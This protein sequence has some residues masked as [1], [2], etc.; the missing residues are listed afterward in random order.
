ML[1]GHAFTLTLFVLAL[2]TCQSA[3]IDS[4]P[5]ELV[6]GSP[7]ATVVSKAMSLLDRLQSALKSPSID[8]AQSIV[9]ELR[10]LHKD[11]DPKPSPDG[12]PSD[13][14]RWSVTRYLLWKLNYYGRVWQL[15]L[16]PSSEM[17]AKGSVTLFKCD[18]EEA[19]SKVAK[20]ATEV[21]DRAAI[22]AAAPETTDYAEW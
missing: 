6:S 9:E 3:P 7:S 15:A 12:E 13:E 18:A 20:E 4:H 21:H 19:I 17:K 11:L 2:D 10:T 22:A 5:A 16:P 8:E 1:P 14:S